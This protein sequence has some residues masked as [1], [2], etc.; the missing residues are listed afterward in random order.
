MVRTFLGGLVGGVILFVMGFIFWATPLGEIPY[1]QAGDPESAAIQL[2]LNQNLTATGTGAYVIPA[3]RSA[4]GAIHYAQGPIATVFFNT[5]G[6]SPD[7]TTM[8]L[9]G[10]I[11]ALVAG[12]LMAFG[13]A[14][15]GGGG[16][17]FAGTARLVVLFSLG[18]CVWEYLATPIFNHFGWTYWI[19]SFVAEAVSL[20]LAGLVI[21]R[22]FLPGAPDVVEPVAAPADAP[23]TED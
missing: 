11:A 9:P 21:A 23:V 3:T 2:A 10:F 5:Q 8:L 7:D 12:L 20:I 17:G 15:V 22:W 13:L 19:Y 6:Y 18:F 1:S 16:R 4:E 14:A